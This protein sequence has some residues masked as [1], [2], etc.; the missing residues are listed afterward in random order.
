MLSKFFSRGCGSIIGLL[1]TVCRVLVPPRSFLCII[2]WKKKTHKNFCS[3][4]NSLLFV[5]IGDNPIGAYWFRQG[6]S[7]GCMAPEK[8]TASGASVSSAQRTKCVINGTI[9]GSFCD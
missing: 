6:W 2:C 1:H 4:S 8:I 9:K 3:H 7:T 5:Y